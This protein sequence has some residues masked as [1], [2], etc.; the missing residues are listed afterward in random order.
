MSEEG[1][2]D[3]HLETVF[4]WLKR[5]DRSIMV[6]NVFYNDQFSIT[7]TLRDQYMLSSYLS[8]MAKIVVDIR[9]GSFSVVQTSNI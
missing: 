9:A 7:R 2:R 8:H 5:F 4:P 6:G 1:T 3:D